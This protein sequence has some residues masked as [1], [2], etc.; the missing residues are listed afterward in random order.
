[1]ATGANDVSHI[2]KFKGDQLIY[3]PAEACSKEP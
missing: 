2:T 3:I 1:M